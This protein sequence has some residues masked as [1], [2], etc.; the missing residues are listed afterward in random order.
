MVDAWAKGL[1]P[2]G[3]AVVVRVD[4]HKARRQPRAFGMQGFMRGAADAPD[5]G[6]TPIL[7]A[8][9]GA[10]GFSAAAVNNGGA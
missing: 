8:D 3:L 1:V 2:G 6:N 5:L 10:K 9:V 7:D 4:V